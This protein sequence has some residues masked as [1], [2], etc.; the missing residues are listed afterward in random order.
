MEQGTREF[1]RRRVAPF[2]LLVAAFAVYAVLKPSL[3]HDQIVH[4]VLGD[5]APRVTELSIRYGPPRHG[6]AKSEKHDVEWAREVT[7]HYSPPPAGAGAPRIVT[8][9]PRL[10]DAD[11]LVEVEV[12][13]RNDRAFLE[14]EVTLGGGTTSIDVS[15]VVP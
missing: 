15:Q 4:V 11:Y 12:A 3:P 9:D 14:R 6:V 2:L 7:F 1:L 5:A 8:H 10:P 13:T